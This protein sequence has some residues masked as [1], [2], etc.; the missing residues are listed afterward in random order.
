VITN[1]KFQHEITYSEKEIFVSDLFLNVLY[2][3][4]KLASRTQIA[5]L[6]VHAAKCESVSQ[7]AQRQ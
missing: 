7:K 3:G 4:V 1:L 5:N 2:R 6:V